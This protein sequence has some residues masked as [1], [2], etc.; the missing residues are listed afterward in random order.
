MRVNRQGAILDNKAGAARHHAGELEGTRRAKL[1]EGH[2]QTAPRPLPAQHVAHSC[3]VIIHI[4][5]FQTH[6]HTH[7]K[8]PNPE[9]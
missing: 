8:V 6:T 3:S 1:S 9:M 2:Q 7:K 5:N 4:L